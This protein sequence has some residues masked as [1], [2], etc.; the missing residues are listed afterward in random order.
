LQELERE[1]QEEIDA[2]KSK[3][4]NDIS[5]TLEVAKLESPPKLEPSVDSFLEMNDEIKKVNVYDFL[6]AYR[7]ALNNAY[8]Q[9][10]PSSSM[11]GE[12]AYRQRNTDGLEKFPGIQFLG[13]SLKGEAFKEISRLLDVELKYLKYM[14]KGEFTLLLES[15]EIDPHAASEE[16]HSAQVLGCN[17]VN[18]THSEFNVCQS[19]DHLLL[20]VNKFGNMKDITFA[21]GY[22]ISND[23][24]EQLIND[25]KAILRCADPMQFS[26]NDNN[27]AKQWLDGE[28]FEGFF[29]DDKLLLFNEMSKE[30][31]KAF[32]I[33]EHDIKNHGQ[34]VISWDDYFDLRENHLSVQIKQTEEV[35]EQDEPTHPV[36]SPLP[37]NKSAADEAADQEREL[38]NKKIK[39]ASLS[40]KDSETDPAKTHIGKKW[41]DLTPEE[42]VARRAYNKSQPNR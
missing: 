12:E 29:S 36:A 27:V 7:A 34:R 28:L 16:L 18:E 19:Q 41:K 11:T 23:G 32:G 30:V 8:K 4:E 17:A 25:V 6:K 39:S 35:V 13:I 2:L 15:T 31:S 5:E 26:G 37:I 22:T 10:Y 42:Q 14:R 40:P 1:S 24:A 38:I 33:T 20:I 3:K 9:I 21:K